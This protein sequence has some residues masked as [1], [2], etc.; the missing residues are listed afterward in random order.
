MNDDS[1]LLSPKVSQMQDAPMDMNGNIG[2]VVKDGIY[3]YV[4]PGVV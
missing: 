2:G 1:L 3:A 4:A